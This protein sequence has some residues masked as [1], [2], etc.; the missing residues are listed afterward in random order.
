MF[1]NKTVIIAFY[2]G[3][4]KVTNCLA[5]NAFKTN[6]VPQI[7]NALDKGGVGRAEWNKFLGRG[8]M[9]IR[10]VADAG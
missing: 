10:H 7:R 2:G 3:S 8:T 4:V 6:S 9:T 5:K 1:C